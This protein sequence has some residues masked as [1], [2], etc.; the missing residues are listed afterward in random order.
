VANSTEA[1][2]SLLSPFKT[3]KLCNRRQLTHLRSLSHSPKYVDIVDVSVPAVLD[4]DD[5]EV[6]ADVSH[7]RFSVYCVKPVAL[8]VTAVSFIFVCTP[9]TTTEKSTA[10]QEDI[11]KHCFRHSDSES[12]VYNVA[13]N[14]ATPSSLVHVSH[15][16]KHTCTNHTDV[17]TYKI[18]SINIQSTTSCNT[19]GNKQLFLVLRKIVIM[20]SGKNTIT[21]VVVKHVVFFNQFYHDSST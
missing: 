13:P 3:D 6:T 20:I 11:S 17:I 4:V 18:N 21:R 9:H 12:D 14:D 5:A 8:T 7:A 10:T 19:A 2:M 15:P 16:V 1:A